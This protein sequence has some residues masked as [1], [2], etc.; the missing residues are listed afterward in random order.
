S[1][2]KRP[3]RRQEA[4]ARPAPLP[5]TALQIILTR[6]ARKSWVL[7]SSI[8]TAALNESPKPNS[9]RV[10]EQRPPRAGGLRFSCKGKSKLLTAASRALESS[11]YHSVM[12]QEPCPRLR[13]ASC[14]C[15][16]P[17]SHSRVSKRQPT[18]RLCQ[19]GHF[20]R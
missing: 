2:Q 9:A 15:L 12:A 18:G 19:L 17:S 13:Q 20:P 11:R 3:L 1:C 6:L 8:R 4:D 16:C 14:S 10:L 7:N 5:E